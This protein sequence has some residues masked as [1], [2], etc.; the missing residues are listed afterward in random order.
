MDI[1]PIYISKFNKTREHH[2]NLLMITDGT[3]T[4]HYIAIKKIPALLR[5]ASS[6]HDGDYYCLNCFH[7][8]RTESSLK[9][10]EELCVNNNFSLI[11][12]P[13]EDK[14]YISST[15]GKNT[16]KN[17]F[18]I[19]ADF[20]CLLYPLSTC[21]NT[22]ENSFT[23]KE[24]IH[25]PSGFSMLTSYAYDKSLNKP[26]CYHGKDCLA[27]FSKALKD[28]VNKII[29]I[30]QKPMDPLTDQE[31]E[32]YPN[33]K[34]CFICEKPFGETK[35]D[36][37]VRD[38]C[39]YTGKYRGAAHNACNLQYKV[40]KSIPVVIHNGSSYDF[41]LIIKQLAH[42][43][44][45]PFSC[46][47]ENTEKYITFSISIFKKTDANDKPIAYQIKFIDSYRH[48]NQSLSNLVDNLAELNK[49]L[50]VNT[51]IN[52]FYNTYH[53]LSDNNIEK[54]K[55]LLRKGVYPYEYMRS[56]KNCKKPVPLNKE[57]YYSETNNTNISDDDLEHVKKVCNAFKGTLMQI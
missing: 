43:F 45:G 46:L 42:D 52:R 4:W 51:L 2:A 15:P 29:S 28:E 37:K 40:P 50:P 54:F 53:A 11:K 47:G 18:I 32:S 19:Y 55:L 17:P 31:K 33:A 3:D 14:K 27:K 5:G 21:D 10:H 44:K 13:T 8:Y 30:K 12:M 56:W 24:N 7:S 35:S 57:C 49:N 9:K 41:H 16:L 22:E 20:E 48:M 25:R 26:I 34:T 1:R 23:I 36:I 6:T 38:H 39:H